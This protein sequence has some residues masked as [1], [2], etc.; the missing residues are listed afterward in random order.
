VAIDSG[1]AGAPD[2]DAPRARTG[3]GH[4]AP[5]WSGAEQDRVGDATAA[6]RDPTRG[7]QI[8][9]QIRYRETVEASFQCAEAREAWAAA[10][11]ALRAEWEAHKQ[12]YPR[13]EQPPSATLPDGGWVGEGNRRLSPEQNAEAAKCAADLRDEA[14]QRIG[15]AMERIEAA[16]PG[17]RLAGREHMLKGEDRLKEKIADELTA[18]P[19]IAVRESLDA[20]ADRVRF[21]LEYPAE[22]YSEGVLTD[23][24]RMKAEGFQLVRL[25]NL[26]HADQYKGVNTQW[27]AAETG[28]RCEMQFHTGESLEAKELTHQAYERI[29]TAAALP[30]EERD[31]AEEQ[32]LESFQSRVNAAVVTPPGTDAIEDFPRKPEQTIG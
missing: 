12:R 19:S 31:F 3:E 22:R 32:L 29:R 30:V 17:R 24:Q 8:E 15:P 14:V 21:T 6:G 20:V 28:T 16:D 23:I 9:E 11:P 7:E 5:D 18:Q 13:S 26:W 27:R 25:K 2:A 1:D 4:D 10:A